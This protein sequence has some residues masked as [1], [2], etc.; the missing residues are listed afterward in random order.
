MRRAVLCLIVLCAAAPAFAQ[1]RD[2]LPV[3]AV[4]ARGA[5]V[6]LKQDPVTASTLGI[7]VGDLATR[8]LGIVAGAHVYPLRGQKMA[9]GIGGELFLARGVKQNLDA[10]DLPLG[11]EVRRQVQSISAQI[12]LNFGHR[13][14]WS[15]LTVGMGPLSFDTYLAGTLPD[16]ARTMTQNFGFGARWFT[17]P[18]VAFTVDMRFYL[19]QPANPTDVVGGRERHA[20][21]VMSAG[22][23]L[24]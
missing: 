8:G 12:S 13:R 21:T 2:S 20:L 6:L 16:G 14:G 10:E 1:A 24:K 11:P 18:H 15:Y 19:T 4:D 9:L 23:S 17:R 22:I 5:F 3:F 7:T